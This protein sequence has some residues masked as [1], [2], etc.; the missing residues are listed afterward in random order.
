MKH[1]DQ[2]GSWLLDRVAGK[3]RVVSSL[4]LSLVLSLSLWFFAFARRKG[5]WMVL[6]GFDGREERGKMDGSPCFVW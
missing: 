6:P 1:G 5:S 3:K 2:P 4:S